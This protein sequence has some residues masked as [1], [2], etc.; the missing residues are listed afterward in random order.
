VFVVLQVK[1]KSNMYMQN[2]KKQKQ[3]K[4]NKKNFKKKTNPPTPPQIVRLKIHD[5]KSE[6]KLLTN[7]KK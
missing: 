2:K 5:Q 7:T 3:N 6:K 4:Q 1:R